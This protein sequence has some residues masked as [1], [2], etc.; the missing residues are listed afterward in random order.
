MVVQGKDR[1][2][3]DVAMKV[4]WKLFSLEDGFL[5]PRLTT[6]VLADSLAWFEKHKTW[7]IR[8]DAT[9]EYDDLLNQVDRAVY[10]IR[11]ELSKR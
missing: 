7:L 2:A 6:L 1:I 11:T 10:R 3:E 8:H 4:D 9:G 5:A